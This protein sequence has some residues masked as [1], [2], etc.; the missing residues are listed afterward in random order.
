VPLGEHD[1]RD[2]QRGEQDHEQSHAVEA[3]RVVR[4][5]GLD[6][7]LVL[8]RS[9]PPRCTAATMIEYTNVTS[10]IASPT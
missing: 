5:E 3:E 2:Q 8:A 1:H 7:H 9:V 6:P 10:A 4:A